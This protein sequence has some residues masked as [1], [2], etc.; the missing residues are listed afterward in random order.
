MIFHDYL[1]QI[2]SRRKRTRLV[3]HTQPEDYE[4]AETEISIHRGEWSLCVLFS[5]SNFRYK[6]NYTDN[7]NPRHC[8][9]NGCESIWRC[10]YDIHTQKAEHSFFSHTSFL[11]NFTRTRAK[12][13]CFCSSIAIRNLLSLS[14]CSTRSYNSNI[15]SSLWKT[16]C[17]IKQNRC[18]R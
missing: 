7:C 6:N 10:G 4:N 12:S 18:S 5:I 2:V 14:S 8:R 1:Q 17:S 16:C 3:K 15:L 13:S 11:V 9:I